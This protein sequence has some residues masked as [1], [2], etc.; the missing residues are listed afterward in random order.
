[1][2]ILAIT[3]CTMKLY[4]RISLSLNIGVMANIN[5]DAHVLHQKKRWWKNVR[6]VISKQP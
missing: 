2:L 3:P 4:Q 5:T 1:V 6:N